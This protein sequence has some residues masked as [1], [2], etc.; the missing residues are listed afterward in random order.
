MNL[1]YVLQSLRRRPAETIAAAVSVALTV[2]FLI[3]LGSF[4]AQTG[5]RLT[6]RAAARVPVDWQVQV[7]PG[8]DPAVTA[9]ALRDIPGL[10]RFRAVDYAKVP[11]LSSVSAD[12][13]TRTTGAA[14]VVSVPDDYRSFAPGEIRLLVG[15]ADGVI[16]Q[17]Q[18]ASNLSAAPGTTV[19]VLGARRTAQVTGVADLPNADSFFQVVGAP[20]GSGASAPP[21]NVLLVSPARF[22]TLTAGATVV[23][24]F[25]L[26]LERASLPTDPA[27][28][29]DEVTRRANHLVAAVAGGALIG[30]NLGTSL[31]AAREDAIY[32]R[33]LVLLLGVPGLL[34]AGVVTAL[35]VSLRNDRQRR[36]L[37]LLRLR[38]VS[39]RRAAILIGGTALLDGLIGAAVGV[40]VALLAPRFGPYGDPSTTW[41]IAG[42]LTGVLLALAT[43]LTPLARTLR[44]SAPTVQAG[45]NPLPPT[46]TPLALR[47]G[48]DVVLLTGSA[49]VFWLTAR[50]GY[51]V[52]VVPE[53]VPV[54]SVNYAALLAP[55]LAWPGMALL[56]WR[57]TVLA[58]NRAARTP[59]ADRSG[60]MPDL[61]HDVVRRRRIPIARGVTGLAIAVAVTVSAAVFTHT[62]DQ[63][64]RLD[65]ALT[66]GSDVAVTLP[67]DST[68]GLDPAIAAVPGAAA[69]EQVSHR[70]VYVGPDLQDLYGIDAATIGRAAPL[71]DAFTPG[72][73]IKTALGRLAAT[74]DGALLSQETLHDY[75]LRTGDTVQLRLKDTGGAY[76]TVRFHVVGVITEFATAPRDSFVLANRSY[77]ASATGLSAVQTLLVRTDRPASVAAAIHAPAAALVNDIT[78]PRVAVPSA[79]G[80]AAGSLSGLSRL[81]LAFGILLAAASAGLVLVV[82]ATQR[83]RSTT[84]LAILDA[85]PRQRSGF[86][87]TEA[88]AL[89][90]A[91]AIGGL[92]AA[93]VIA[94][95]LIKVLNGIFDP[96]P[97][98]PAVPW[99][100]VGAVLAA[101]IASAALATTLATRWAGRVDPSRLRDL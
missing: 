61:R 75:Q 30:D 9:T 90:I 29:A 74:P 39:P 77:I 15:A 76:R 38:G 1:R 35:V 49:I 63:Q 70:L 44:G 48:L 87:W 81:T 67:P 47:L 37:A 8:S 6:L 89:T 98:H 64:A 68:T 95:E 101:A 17:Q 13:G 34:L 23:H 82:G 79:S 80:L 71:Q 93:T 41:L 66:V 57:V 91:G 32:A 19:T 21:D 97:Q 59:D 7:T 18:T 69:V 2:A 83:R 40:G 28:A 24:Q 45:V 22:T 10:L 11:G 62:Y 53:G 52:V 55:A 4:T 16:L 100:F 51:Q 25:H 33:L 12:G 50:G 99:L 92:A 31:S 3:L 20:P 46:R 43:E 88:R 56:I 54:A 60:S 5:A 65:T 96:P 73:S 42:A 72:S 78:A 36:D 58:L 27:K 84:A 26:R 94:A 14:Y 85:S 86:L